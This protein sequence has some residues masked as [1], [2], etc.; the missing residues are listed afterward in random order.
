MGDELG[1]AGMID[2]FHPG[3][4]ETD[5]PVVNAKAANKVRYIPR[6]HNAGVSN[7]A[8]SWLR[9]RYSDGTYWLQSCSPSSPRRS[10]LL[11]D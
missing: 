7:L 5:L 9:H 8:H 6:S 1:I 3:D 2:S 11:G 4:R 10:P